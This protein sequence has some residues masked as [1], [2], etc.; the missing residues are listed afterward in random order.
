MFG[1]SRSPC[2]SGDGVHHYRS[3]RRSD[4]SKERTH[5]AIGVGLCLLGTAFHGIIGV[6]DEANDLFFVFH[7]LIVWRVGL[8]LLQWLYDTGTLWS[9]SSSQTW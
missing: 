6:I 2:A 4:E 7:R 3:Q 9:H 1:H 5:G 8:D